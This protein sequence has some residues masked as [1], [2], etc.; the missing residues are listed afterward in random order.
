MLKLN[1]KEIIYGQHYGTNLNTSYVEV[2]LK[3][4]YSNNPPVANLNTSYVEVKHHSYKNQ[5]FQLLHLNTSYVEVKHIT[6]QN[7]IKIMII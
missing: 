6:Y 7:Y 5:L 2:K 4:S 3:T 1:Q